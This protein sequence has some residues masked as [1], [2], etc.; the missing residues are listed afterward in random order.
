MGTDKAPIEI[1]DKP[2][3]RRVADEI[4]RANPNTAEDLERFRHG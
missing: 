1:G 2:L 3:A 4:G